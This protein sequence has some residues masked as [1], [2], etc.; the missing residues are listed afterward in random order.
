MGKFVEKP[1]N[2]RGIEEGETEKIWRK[3]KSKKYYKWTAGESENNFPTS[4]GYFEK[5]SMAT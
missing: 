1:R 3:K 5:T 4:T 2:M